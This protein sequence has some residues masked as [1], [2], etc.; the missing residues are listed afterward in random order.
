MSLLCLL[1]SCPSL[2]ERFL[3][4]LSAGQDQ[5][6]T[7]WKFYF[8]LY[9]FLDTDNVP[10]DSVEFAFMFEQVG[11]CNPP[12]HLPLHPPPPTY[13]YTQNRVKILL[14]Y[15]YLIFASLVLALPGL[16]INRWSRF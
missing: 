12:P 7:G 5:N 11:G 3:S 16:T 1:T 10:R 4:R 13:P 2:T 6:N 15:F 9:C 14:L 8:K